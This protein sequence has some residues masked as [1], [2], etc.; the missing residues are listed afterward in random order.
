MRR[1]ALA[2]LTLTA[3]FAIP[4]HAETVRLPSSGDPAFVAQLPD[5]WTHETYM[6]GSLKAFSPDHTAA[7]TLVIARYRGTPEEL[8]ATAIETPDGTP[9]LNAGA[10]AISGYAGARFEATIVDDDVHAKVR[11]LVVR[12]DENHMAA[13]T[14]MT[15][16]NLA[17]AQSDAAI[18]VLNAITLTKAEAPPA[19]ETPAPAPAPETPATPPP[20][21]PAPPPAKP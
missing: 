14:L 6:D 12:V 18:A 16:E 13:A 7:I 3:P 9:P 4:A 5:G 21:E 20:P 8:A 2:V 17:A 19:P 10:A 1:I 15:A 11:M